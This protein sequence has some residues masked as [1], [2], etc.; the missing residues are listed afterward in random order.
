MMTMTMTMLDDDDEPYRTV[1]VNL[2]LEVV[3]G[4]EVVL[5]LGRAV[6]GLQLEVLPL[7]EVGDSAFF[8]L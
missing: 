6:C 1:A 7:D 5:V 8:G 3:L 4:A 2:L